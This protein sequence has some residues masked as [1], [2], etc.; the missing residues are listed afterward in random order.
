MKEIKVIETIETTTGAMAGIALI[1]HFTFFL[2]YALLDLWQKAENIAE[3]IRNHNLQ[4]LFRFFVIGPAIP[5]GGITSCFII[6]VLFFFFYKIMRKFPP[7]NAEKKLDG[8][9]E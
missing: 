5:L 6:V 9:G 7:A 1:L 2:F 3:I 4:F 8:Q